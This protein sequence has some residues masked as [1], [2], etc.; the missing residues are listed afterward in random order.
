MPFSGEILLADVTSVILDFH[1][2]G[3]NVM[4]EVVILHERVVAVWTGEHLRLGVRVFMTNKMRG[5]VKSGSTLITAVRFF[6]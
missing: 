3:L 4:F 2:N 6:S 1:V 5:T